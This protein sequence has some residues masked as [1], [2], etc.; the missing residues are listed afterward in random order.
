MEVKD[1]VISVVVPLVATL[2]S[3]FGSR[4]GTKVS[5]EEFENRKEAT[6]PELLRLEK[7]STILKDS[8]DYPERIKYEL[9]VDTIQSTYN[10]ILKRATL[11]NCVMGLGISTPEIRK[12]LLFIKPYRG[13]GSYPVQSWNT[14]TG[15]KNILF[16]ILNIIFVI[17]NF[18]ILYVAYSNFKNPI[19]EP[20]QA[21]ISFAVGVIIVLLIL[22]FQILVICLFMLSKKPENSIVFRNGYHALRDVYLARKSIS[23]VETPKENE[24]R[25]DFEKSKE[26][27]EWWDK[28]KE[29]HPEWTS[30]NYGLSISWDNNPDKAKTDE[31][32]PESPTLIQKLSRTKLFFKRA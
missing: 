22:V 24:E 27:K 31:S 29:D 16:I 30:W 26:Y 4:R 11:E 9:D 13:D 19:L 5:R 10:D 14:L 3:Y 18:Y 32:E 15:R 6:P 7:W 21:W 12:A 28:V 1:V 20:W 8:S 23:L 2:M 25:K 17:L